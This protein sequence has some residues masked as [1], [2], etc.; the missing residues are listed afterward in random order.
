ML[1]WYRSAAK[2]IK[3][4]NRS[5]ALLRDAIA[6]IQ[7]RL[8]NCWC[9][10][11]STHFCQQSSRRRKSE[12]VIGFSNL[13]K[14]EHTEQICI[15]YPP[16]V[17]THS[18]TD[19]SVASIDYCIR[20]LLRE[21]RLEFVVTGEVTGCSQLPWLSPDKSRKR[22]LGGINMASLKSVTLTLLALL[23]ISGALAIPDQSSF[24]GKLVS[25]DTYIHLYSPSRW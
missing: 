24:P 16:V 9:C 5:G 23:R 1:C 18:T 4:V 15:R 14:A 25:S 8:I 6:A 21:Q 7:L 12:V 11:R 22:N 2:I 20:K 13:P 10:F 19:C 3:T 17:C